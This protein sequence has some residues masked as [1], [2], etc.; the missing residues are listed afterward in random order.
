MGC[1]FSHTDASSDPPPEP[2]GALASSGLRPT[3]S[4]HSL[5]TS[6]AVAAASAA[7]HRALK[8]DAS[9][10]IHNYTVAKDIGRIHSTS[11]ET[12]CGGHVWIARRKKEH[13]TSKGVV[14]ARKH[15]PSPT[16]LGLV[17][18]KRL[19]VALVESAHHQ[20]LVRSDGELSLLKAFDHPC[21]VNLLAFWH[22]NRPPRKRKDEEDEDEVWGGEGEVASVDQQ[23][24]ARSFGTYDNADPNAHYLFTSNA[25]MEW[26]RFSSVFDYL[27]VQP[28]GR[29]SEDL[30]RVYAAEVMLAMG[31]LHARGFWYHTF[32]I[33]DVLL[34][35]DGH[36]KLT[37]PLTMPRPGRRGRGWDA[38]FKGSHR[39][40]AS[41]EY[42]APELL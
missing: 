1:R 9:H 25:L 3:P 15:A 12:A 17:A 26:R 2:T 31:E 21:L 42:L 24:A 20:S 40:R 8:P 6:S 36:A 38:S 7:F 29:F 41:I 28:R 35:G 10:S 34:D 19:N 39:Y 13:T 4:S 30:A 14:L 37:L 32:R 23:G 22:H 33:E 16:R 18:L 5:F 11:P 27:R